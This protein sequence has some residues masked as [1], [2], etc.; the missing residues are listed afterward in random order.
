ML[1]QLV[2]LALSLFASKSA[3]QLSEAVCDPGYEWAFNSKGQSPCVMASY[4]YAVCGGTASMDKLEPGWVYLTPWA[5]YSNP[6]QCNT[7]TYSLSNVCQLCQTVASRDL[8]TWGTWTTNC[9][10]ADISNGFFPEEIPYGTA[11]PAWAFQSQT[12]DG[13]FSLIEAQNIAD[14]NKTEAMRAVPSSSVPAPSESASGSA[15]IPSGG[16]DTDKKSSSSTPVGAIVGGVVGGVAGLALLLGLGW[17]LMRRRRNQGQPS[18]TLDTNPIMLPQ[19]VP[20]PMSAMT[21]H[22]LYDPNDPTTFPPPMTS[23]PPPPSG[24]YPVRPEL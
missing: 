17:F 21:E 14:T 6:C 15:P 19:P 22:K 11:I 12:T 24:M 23:S 9:S 4:L 7:V 2:P 20:T 8:Y 3:A 13:R 5:N 16:Q 10:A 1:L 18:P